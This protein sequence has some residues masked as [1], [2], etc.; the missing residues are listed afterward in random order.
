MQEREQLINDHSSGL[1]SA[2]ELAER[3]GI[4][5]KTVH[6]W[7]KRY[8]GDGMAGLREHSRAP[9]TCPHRTDAAIV[10]LLLKQRRKHPTWGSRKIRAILQRRHPELELPAASTIYDIFERHGLV[11]PRRRSPAHAPRESAGGIV[12]ETPNAL[13]T[14]DFKGEFRLGNRQYCYPLTIVDA[15]S[16]FIL[17][18]R[19][20]PG[21]GLLGVETAFERL[22]RRRGLPQ[23]L[24][25]DNGVPWVSHGIQG[26]SRLSAAWIRLGIR[27]QPTDRGHPEQNPR[28]E[29]MHR[30]LKQETTRPPEETFEKQQRRFDRFVGE[31]NHERPHQSL[32]QKTPASVYCASLR[33]YPKKTPQPQYQGHWE[34]RTVSSR[35]R[36][37]VAGQDVF[38]STVISGQRVALDEIDD[39]IWNV[40]YYTMLLG[41]L[42][43]SV[44][45]LQ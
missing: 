12:A 40:Y 7:L 39:G 4:S 41:R 9:L 37:S 13:W 29:R 10:A 23:A 34:L 30:T 15:H 14:L 20:L 11:E 44:G 22:F 25:F 32:E 3:Y 6:K 42:D 28:H 19:A 26:L 38:I 21:T 45:I 18:C 16:R 31:Y 8:R 2:R 24:R 33:P 36:I 27:L 5:A 35:G 1:Y 17:V 43:Q